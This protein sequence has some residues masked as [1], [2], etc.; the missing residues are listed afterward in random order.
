MGMMY[1]GNLEKASRYLVHVLTEKGGRV[2]YAHFYDGSEETALAL[3]TGLGV[4]AEEGEWMGAEGVMDQA[5]GEM[6]AQ[7][8]VKLV[9]LPGE[10][11][12]DDEPAYEIHLTD[13]GRRRL[14]AGEWPTFRDLDL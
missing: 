8:F 2:H 12:A 6:E 4:D 1:A 14:A 10:K 13:E 5:A 9:W 3:Y 11:L 7:G